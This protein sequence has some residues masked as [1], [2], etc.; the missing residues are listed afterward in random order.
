MTVRGFVR[1]VAYPTSSPVWFAR[2]LARMTANVGIG[3]VLML[4]FGTMK[5]V[6]D[7]LRSR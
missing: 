5:K 6:K 2:Q 7:A 1:R 4:T 3:L